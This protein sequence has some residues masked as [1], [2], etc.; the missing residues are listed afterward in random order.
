MLGRD[1]LRVVTIIPWADKWTE[2]T[3]KRAWWWSDHV[4]VGMGTWQ[5]V[6]ADDLGLATQKPE[7]A[8]AMNY[9]WLSAGNRYDLK[10]DDFVC[11][12][13]SG[14]VFADWGA[15][16]PALRRHPHYRLGVTA[17]QMW[18]PTEYR[19]DW[20]PPQMVFPFVPYK[21][22][23]TFDHPLQYINR[24]PSAAH[25]TLTVG[26]SIADLLSYRY[27]DEETREAWYKRCQTSDWRHHKEWSEPIMKPPRLETYRKGGLL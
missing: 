21:P 13:N 1:E 22:A 12:L 15:I 25:N 7:S 17:Y 26:H 11:F 18:T 20:L 23:T 16:R 9:L 19:T 8:Q 5:N 2:D 4:L 3:V 14:E 10:P 24:G 27:A 6:D